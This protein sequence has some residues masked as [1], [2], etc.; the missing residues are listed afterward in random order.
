ML[1]RNTTWTASRD[2]GEGATFLQPT[3][4]DGQGMMVAADSG[5][6]AVADMDDAVVCVAA[7]HDD[8][9]QRGDR[10]RPG[11]GSTWEVRPF[12]DQPT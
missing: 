7:G 1:V 8:G 12:D 2:G 6:A 10:V 4:Y 9:G 11:S 3:F 5:F